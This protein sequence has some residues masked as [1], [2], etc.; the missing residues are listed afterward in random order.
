MHAYVQAPNGTYLSNIIVVRQTYESYIDTYI[1]Q[2][3]IVHIVVIQPIVTMPIYKYTYIYILS[4]RHVHY[5]YIYTTYIY[6]QW[7]CLSY[8]K[9][10]VNAHGRA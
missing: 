7:S 1:I 4:T 10:R 9:R 6:M 3:Q 8:A 5:T 2:I